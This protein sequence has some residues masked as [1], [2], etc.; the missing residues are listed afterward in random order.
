MDTR[1]ELDVPT[2]E[3]TVSSI[4]VGPSPRREVVGLVSVPCPVPESVHQDGGVVVHLDPPVR[5]LR[6]APPDHRGPFVTTLGVVYVVL[7]CQS[8]LVPDSC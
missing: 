4:F 6:R 1:L 8:L 3:T 2:V 7:P 5:R